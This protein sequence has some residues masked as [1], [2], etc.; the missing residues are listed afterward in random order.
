MRDSTIG[1]FGVGAV[2]TEIL[3]RLASWNCRFR[4][5]GHKDELRIRKDLAVRIGGQ[6]FGSDLVQ[7]NIEI[8]N[9]KKKFMDGLD[10]AV[11]AVPL[12]DDT[13]GMVN[14]SFLQHAKRGLVLVN[15]A[16]QEIVDLP[17]LIGWQTTQDNLAIYI[18]D[19]LEEQVEA[20]GNVAL[21]DLYQHKH[22]LEH[23]SWRVRVTPHVAGNTEE[24]LTGMVK[25]LLV[26]LLSN[27]KSNLL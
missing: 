17:S 19:T 8:Q 6:P 7:A 4:I 11:I 27:E 12:D 13:R 9:D 3:I 21:S 22:S 10:I 20:S 15:C 24:A 1:F 18:T 26:Q 5:F 14:S 2:T 23:D 25:D 16:R